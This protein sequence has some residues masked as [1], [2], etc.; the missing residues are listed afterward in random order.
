MC[1]GWQL[2]VHSFFAYRA[3][4]LFHRVSF[5]DYAGWQLYRTRYGLP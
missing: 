5:L 3:S 4:L 2:F 1:S